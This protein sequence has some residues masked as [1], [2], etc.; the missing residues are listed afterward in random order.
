VTV[1]SEKILEKIF[2]INYKTKPE[3]FLSGLVLVSLA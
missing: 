3:I 1:A 2:Q